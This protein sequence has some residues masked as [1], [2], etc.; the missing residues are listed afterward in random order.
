MK[1]S[2]NDSYINDTNKQFYIETYDNNLSELLLQIN[3]CILTKI[4][5]PIHIH[6]ITV[7][8]P[9]FL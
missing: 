1:T 2:H 3:L 4:L 9:Y 6:S 5:C 8:K 7:K